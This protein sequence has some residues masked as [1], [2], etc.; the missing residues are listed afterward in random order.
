M[1]ETPWGQSQH[2]HE[3]AVGIMFH[4][5]ASHGG[6]HLA[7][8]RYA[9]FCEIPEF[10]N[11]GEWLE[12][13]CDACLVYLRWPEL[14]T[15]EQV[16][17]AVCMVRAMAV[18]NHNTGRWQAMLVWIKEYHP[19]LLAREQ[20]HLEAVKDLWQRGTMASTKRTGIWRVWFNRRSQ[21]ISIYMNYPTKRY[22]TD[23]E[24]ESA[25]V[26]RALC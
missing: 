2:Q 8:N 4:S 18:I 12:E 14:A 15:D 11:W 16:H 7:A 13:D 26:H 25:A 24:L 3:H 9:Q 19:E 21:T 6:Y 10:A 5:T 20:A 1:I 22:Y 17:D 23:A